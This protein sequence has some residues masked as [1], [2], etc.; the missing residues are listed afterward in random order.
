[1]RALA[2]VAVLAHHANTDGLKHWALGNVGVAVFFSIS[3]FLAYYV[4]HHDER[5]LG[6]VDYNYFL[7]RR[8]LRIWPAY[9][10]IIGLVALFTPEHIRDTANWYSLFT[11]TINWDMA[12]FMNWPAGALAPLWS[13]AVE[14]QFYVLAP[15]MYWAM[16]SRYAIPFCVAV[17]AAS[18]IGRGVYLSLE[19]P[20]GNGGLYYA[21]YTYADTFLV[22]AIM[23]QA[24]TSGW[25][26]VPRSVHWL[27]PIFAAAALILVLRL[28][29]PAVFP[30]YPKDAW[31]PYALLPI[32]SL[33]LLIC[34]LP[35]SNSP[36]TKLLSS[37]PFVAV[38]RMS[39]TLYLV[40]LFALFQLLGSNPHAKI[41]TLNM[42]FF[43]LTILLAVGMHY[44]IEQPLRLKQ[45]SKRLSEILRPAFVV[46]FLLLIGG[47]RYVGWL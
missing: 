33:L 26:K 22:G 15:F 31:V 36:V 42:G 46:W 21:T 8:V 40:H 2:V 4:L 38:G 16:R 1:M 23:A 35:L 5:R 7:M 10:A 17:F 24:Y 25:L 37:A 9:L 3:G 39:Y 20:V 47:A 19:H 30:P 12:G 34:A 43:A 32:A 13:I 27:A 11:F 45:Y 28:W 44:C 29:A 6:A 41:K 14:E 18:N